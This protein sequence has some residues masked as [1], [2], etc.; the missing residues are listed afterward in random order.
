MPNPAET[1]TRNK[2]KRKNRRKNWKQHNKQI[3]ATTKEKNQKKP[4]RT[5]TALPP[6]AKPWFR[7]PFIEKT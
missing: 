3:Q 4:S 2:S 6:Q 7:P 5:G 1:V